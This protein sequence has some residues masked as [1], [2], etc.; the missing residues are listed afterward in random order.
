MVAGQTERGQGNS[1]EAS[2][3]VADQGQER[4]KVPVKIN[5]GEAE[6]GP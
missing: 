5:S 4:K 3:L 1:D 2:A 6:L